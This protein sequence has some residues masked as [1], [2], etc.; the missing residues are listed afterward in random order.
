MLRMREHANEK[1]TKMKSQR[2]YF[3]VFLNI[4]TQRLLGAQI[5]PALREHKSD[6][7]FSLASVTE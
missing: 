7:W 3:N 1:W 6:L 4:L 2:C 5:L